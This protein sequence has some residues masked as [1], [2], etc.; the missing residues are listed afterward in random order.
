MHRLGQDA[1]ARQAF[2]E[3]MARHP[4]FGP[5]HIVERLPGEHPR[6]VEGRER[7]LASLREL[8]MR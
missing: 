3:F 7:L 4:G 5:R 1:T 6:F 8:G 2:D